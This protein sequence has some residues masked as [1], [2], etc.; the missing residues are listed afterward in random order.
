MGTKF[1][2]SIENLRAM[3][4]RQIDVFFN[5]VNAKPDGTPIDDVS[6]A[7]DRGVRQTEGGGF[8]IEG[9]SVT[10]KV[11]YKA[12][13]ITIAPGTEVY[14]RTPEGLFRLADP[15]EARINALVQVFISRG[16]VPNEAEALDKINASA[17]LVSPIGISAIAQLSNLVFE[18]AT[19]A[20]P[21]QDAT[22]DEKPP[23][24]EPELTAATAQDVIDRENAEFGRIVGVEGVEQFTKAFI[25]K[26]D[27]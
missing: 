20:K 7:V 10:L 19:S 18:F 9:S 14:V 5:Q 1:D 17:V 2:N 12:P 11:K 24:T 27:E 15:T 8:I 16:L 21:G 22:Y 4:H 6:F 25:E 23:M 13:V 3:A 26:K